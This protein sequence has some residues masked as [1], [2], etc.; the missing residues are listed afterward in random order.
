MCVCRVEGV[1]EKRHPEG[2]S[3]GPYRPLMAGSNPIP[4]AYCVQIYGD[5]KASGQVV[6]ENSP[7]NFERGKVDKFMLDLPVMGTL[8]VGSPWGW[9]LR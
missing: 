9:S 4:H 7:D 2:F 5:T 6:L 3:A 8:Q 1:S